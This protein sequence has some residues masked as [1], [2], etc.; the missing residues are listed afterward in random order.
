MFFTAQ[1]PA[2]LIGRLGKFE[3]TS[4]GR[5]AQGLY[6][7]TDRIRHFQES[8]I[9][10][11]VAVALAGTTGFVAPGAARAA[12]SYSSEN[13]ELRRGEAVRIRQRAARSYLKGR[14]PAQEDNGDENRFEDYRSSFFKT[15]PQNDLGE[16]DQEAYEDLLKALESGRRR[17]FNAI[18]LA[19]GSVRKL[20]NPQGAYAFL[21][22]G[23]AGQSTRIPPA[24]KF[25]SRK[26]AAEMGEV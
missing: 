19:P 4:F 25:T 16:V 3:C 2:Q 11:R 6:D 18:P 10:F 5:S 1:I 26:I 24:P 20:A 7:K 9:Y 17:D 21:M 13:A 22:T 14:I 23:L 8:R 12:Q 15:L